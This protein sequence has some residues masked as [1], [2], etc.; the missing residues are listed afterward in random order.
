M[1]FDH[2]TDMERA[3][4]PYW[5]GYGDKYALHLDWQGKKAKVCT[6]MEKGLGSSDA[7]VG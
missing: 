5:M 2:A 1:V 4:S 7:E 3:Q 6:F